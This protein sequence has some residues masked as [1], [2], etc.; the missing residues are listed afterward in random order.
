MRVKHTEEITKLLY[1]CDKIARDT[2]ARVLALVI[3]EG[4]NFPILHPPE[5]E[6]RE[7]DRAALRQALINALLEL[8]RK[9]TGDDTKGLI[10]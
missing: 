8:R 1:W 2:G 4:P 6:M 5:M 3:E 9:K 10:Q 7:D